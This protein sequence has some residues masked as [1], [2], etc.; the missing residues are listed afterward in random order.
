[1]TTGKDPEKEAWTKIS[2]I[3]DLLSLIA[4]KTRIKEVRVVLEDGRE[5]R[6]TRDDKKD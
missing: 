4:N 1:M 2:N 3:W 5:F 6:Y